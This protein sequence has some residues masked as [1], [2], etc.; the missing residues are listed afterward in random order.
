MLPFGLL[1][2]DWWLGDASF[3]GFAAS[4]CQRQR[5]AFIGLVII[6]VRVLNGIPWHH[7]EPGGCGLDLWS[8]M[9]HFDDW[10]L[11]ISMA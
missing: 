7:G 9:S 11:R 1:V 2:M 5:K 10:L 3:A 4:A 6:R 8:L